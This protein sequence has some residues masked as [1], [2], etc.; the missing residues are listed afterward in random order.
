MVELTVR[1]AGAVRYA[2]RVLRA[3]LTGTEICVRDESGQL[4]WLST[5][6]Q[7][8]WVHDGELAVA[9]ALN[10]RDAAD[11]APWEPA[12][13]VVALRTLQSTTLWLKTAADPVPKRGEPLLAG[14]AVDW[15]EAPH[16]QFRH[17][18]IAQD[19]ETGFVVHISG[20]DP[21]DGD[22]LVEATAIAVLPRNA[23]R[24]QPRLHL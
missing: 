15:F 21:Q 2:P 12:T 11:V 22:L 9:P 14:R 19:S 20:T 10:D 6:E 3:W 1:T 8:A 16:E 7:V 18:E 4:L 13:E 23:A 17:L 24:F 5:P